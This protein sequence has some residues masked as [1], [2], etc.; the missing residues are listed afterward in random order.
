MRVTVYCASSDDAPEKY[1]QDA[2][3]LGAA[4]ADGGHELVY[5]G[6]NIGSMRAIAES[7]EAG[8]AS[9][10]SVIPRFF[11]ER[12]LTFANSTEI[13]LTDDMQQRRRIMWEK[14]DG[15]IALPGGFGTLEEVAEFLTL[16][17]LGILEK[18]LVLADLDGFWRPLLDLYDR[19]T[20]EKMLH[21][22]IRDRVLVA[23][24]AVAAIELLLNWQQ[25]EEAADG[26]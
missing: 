24:D 12:G 18:P 23:P 22:S 2:S 17:Q 20:E 8:G 6:G 1:R 26:N 4:I 25:N 3:A 14:C 13:H 16:N 15:A 10:V 11:D 9:V 19:M 21:S 5:G 7:A